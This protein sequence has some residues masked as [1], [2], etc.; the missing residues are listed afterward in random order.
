[1]KLCQTIFISFKHSF[2]KGFSKKLLKIVFG[3]MT[4]KVI[5]CFTTGLLNIKLGRQHFYCQI[6]YYTLKP[7]MLQYSKYRNR[8][9]H[10][11]ELYC[12]G[13]ILL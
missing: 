2:R 10:I 5:D 9:K 8:L 3:V 7:E 11:M 4:S 13:T 12:C 6:N 1:M